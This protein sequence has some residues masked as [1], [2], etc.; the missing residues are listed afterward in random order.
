MRTEGRRAIC[1]SVSSRSCSEPSTSARSATAAIPNR[2]AP[3]IA[4]IAGQ[5]RQHDQS[6]PP[7][8]VGN[9]LRRPARSGAGFLRHL[10]EP[11]SI[12][13]PP[14]SFRPWHGDGH[15]RAAL[16]RGRPAL[17]AEAGL[18]Q[19]LGRSAAR[20]ASPL[21]RAARHGAP[22]AQSHHRTFV[23]CGNRPAG[24]RLNGQR[25]SARASL[26]HAHHRFCRE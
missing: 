14:G 4:L 24:R 17:P 3:D 9:F 10:P 19:P 16:S 15:R 21:E 7:L 8:N 20:D 6:Q 23:G 5:R 2:V 1:S 11:A 13:L 18:S 12:F 25:N 26:R 22:F